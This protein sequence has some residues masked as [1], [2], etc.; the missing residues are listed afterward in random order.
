MAT[1]DLKRKRPYRL[2]RELKA[3]IVRSG[4]VQANVA[5]QIGITPQHFNA[6]LNGYAPLTDR[7]ARDISR[8]TGIPLAT[9][10]PSEDGGKA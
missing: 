3:E 4:R 8:A 1:L 6:V 2:H 9:I 5:R 7:L 10:L